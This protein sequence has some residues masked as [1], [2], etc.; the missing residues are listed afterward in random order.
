MTI[1]QE[2]EKAVSYTEDRLNV[3]VINL[4]ILIRTNNA[5]VGKLKKTK[6]IKNKKMKKRKHLGQIAILIV[7]G[8]RPWEAEWKACAC[9]LQC[10]LQSSKPIS[11][12]NLKKKKNN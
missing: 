1:I 4:H 9:E 6:E 10:G 12:W 2:P 7:A 8:P 3:P 5:I 11:L